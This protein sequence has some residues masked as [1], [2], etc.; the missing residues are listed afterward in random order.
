[1]TWIE[2]ETVASFPC[3]ILWIVNQELTLKGVDEICTTH[4][5]AGVSRLCFFNHRS[6]K[7]TDIIRCHV[8]NFVVV[9]NEYLIVINVILGAKIQKNFEI[10]DGFSIN[11]AE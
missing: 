8:H 7:D 4:S 2:E 6:S 9:H 3:G 10:G 11:C 5:T 1:M